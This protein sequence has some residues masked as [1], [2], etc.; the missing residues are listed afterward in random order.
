MRCYFVKALYVP[1]VIETELKNNQ[2]K[3]E[4]YNLSL[5]IVDRLT[6]IDVYKRKLC[7]QH[8][9]RIW[10]GEQDLLQHSNAIEICYNTWSKMEWSWHSLGRT[11]VGWFNPA[12]ATRVEYRKP[13]TDI[14][15]TRPVLPTIHGLFLPMVH[16]KPTSDNESV[17]KS[18]QMHWDQLYALN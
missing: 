7:F 8:C 4:C 6:I 2:A 12:V 9:H 10:N 17:Q 15:F 5:V 1:E 14:K 3:R 18:I 13:T 11:S 16:I